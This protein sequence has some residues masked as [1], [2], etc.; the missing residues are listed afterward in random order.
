MVSFR[1]VRSSSVALAWIQTRVRPTASRT[2]GRN[3]LKSGQYGPMVGA[4]C[5]DQTGS[6]MLLRDEPTSD[7]EWYP[8]WKAHPVILP[9]FN[10]SASSQ[11]YADHGFRS[12]RAPRSAGKRGFVTI[13]DKSVPVEQQMR[14][15][16]EGS[17]PRNIELVRTWRE[18]ERVENEDHALAG[19]A[20]LARGKRRRLQW[21]TERPK[22][23]AF[24]DDLI[25]AYGGRCVITGVSVREALEAAHI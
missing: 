2:E 8:I 23:A 19:R 13:I 1:S 10:R 25:A 5:A 14:T 3:L 12:D 6:L 16:G 18:R 11:V 21:Q 7:D 22:Q 9:G 4:K 15:R 17:G 24:R 20:E